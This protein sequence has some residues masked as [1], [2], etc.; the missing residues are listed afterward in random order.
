[1]ADLSPIFTSQRLVVLP[2][3]S[4]QTLLFIGSGE[5]AHLLTAHR[6]SRPSINHIIIYNPNFSKA[7][8]FALELYSREPASSSVIFDYAK[9]L[10]QVIG[11]ADIVCCAPYSRTTNVPI[12]KGKL[13]KPGAH[14]D[15]VGSLTCEMKQCDD[16]AFSRGR[17]FVEE[18]ATDEAGAFVDFAGTLTELAGGKQEGRKR[19]DEVTVFKAVGSGKVDLLVAQFAYE[20]KIHLS[21]FA[22]V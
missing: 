21:N 4:S 9:D 12:V 13:L 6:I 14:L 10:D 16:D 1:M 17:V 22:F 2:P 8:D 20:S 3:S 19:Y 7:L 15:L 18:V 11:M 5:Y